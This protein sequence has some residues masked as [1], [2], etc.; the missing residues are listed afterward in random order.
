[1]TKV[2]LIGHGKW[3]AV[4]DNALSDLKYIKWVDSKDADWIILSTP[5]DLHYEQVS[6]WLGKRKNVF[7][8]KPLTLSYE[9]AKELYDFADTM[10]VRL[11]VDDVFTWRD[12]YDIYDDVNHFVWTKPNQKDTNYIDRL[13]YHHF[14]MWV[15]DTDFE[16]EDITGEPNDF[17][18]ELEDGK[19]AEFFYGDSSQVVH[20]VNNED[21]TNN[22]NNPLRTMFEFLFSDSGD[23]ELNKKLTLNA[24][25]LSEQVRK[26]LLPKALVVGGGIFGT[27]AAVALAHDG[28]QV[29]LHEELEDVM[30]AAS[31][32]NQYRLHKGYHYPRSKETAQECLKG[33]KTFK[34]KYEKSVVNGKIKHYYA[35]ASEDSKVS[36][37]EYLAFLDDM[38]LP[39]ER[40]KPLPNTDVTVLV[41]EEL[42]DSYKLYEA[43]RDKLWSSGVEVIK[44]KTTTKDD[45][46]GYD[47]VVIATYAKLN[48]LLDKKRKYQYELCE[49]PVVRLPRKYEGKS[50]VIMDGP[51]MCLDPYGE[52]NHVL[53]NVKHAIHTWNEGTEAFWPHRYTKYIN[54]G[55][56]ENPEP[57]LTKI[58]KFI[59]TGKKF[60]EDFDKLKHIGSMYT[61]RTVLTNR[62][63]DDARPTLVNH[64]GG[65]VYSLFSGKIDTCV[66][67]ANELI[68]RINND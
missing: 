33:L 44:N 64:E 38:K 59:E 55:V 58:D 7:C 12:D 57:E 4:I 62:D 25:K 46:K 8:E 26:T 42:F 27:T 22:Q 6:H 5:S 35:I 15:G 66:D 50:I 67:A 9:S 11:Y 49:K 14:M 16:I 3:G 51:F 20:F 10:G 41:D 43:A 17:K 61:I 23:Y 63:H 39:Y 56:I 54:K 18:I 30:M 29:E 28:Y 24:T 65:K 52:R 1:M 60:F 40:V 34:R 19:T 45:F 48:D 36:E 68:R 53:G 13:A 2:S 31:D 21:M 32:I 47:V 37:F